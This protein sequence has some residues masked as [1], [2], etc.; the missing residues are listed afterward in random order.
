[1]E[2]TNHSVISKDGTQIGY[3]SI[4]RGPGILFIQGS[5]GTIENF[6]QLAQELADSFTIYLPERRGRGISPKVFTE[7]HSIEKDVE[8]IDALLKETHAKYIFGLSSGGIITLQA[9]L[10]LPGIKKI[11]VYEP[12]LMVD[13]VPKSLD[14][15]KEEMAK[16]NTAD[17]L[18]IAMKASEMGPSFLGRMPDW[19]LVSLTKK[20]LRQE[21]KKT[22]SGGTRFWHD[23]A[24]TLQYDFKIIAEVTPRWRI[25]KDLKIETLLLGGS[26]SPKYLT[27]ALG[28]LETVLP[29][30]KR[31]EFEGLDHGAA[32]NYHKRQNPHGNPRLVAE[33]LREFFTEL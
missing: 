14:R 7:D 31:I 6:T 25:F 16:G 28:S 8:D 23:V 26:K 22:K 13:G 1:M 21:D 18:V 12:P 33:K 30:F 10:Q 17:A 9:A 32:W 19:L 3:Q 4:G 29:K 24:P 20:L 5:M 11:A 15:F 27:R 2:F